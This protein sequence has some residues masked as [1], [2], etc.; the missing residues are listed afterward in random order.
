MKVLQVCNLIRMGM[1]VKLA[2]RVKIY[3]R[4]LV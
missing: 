4:R 3:L 1:E 2:G